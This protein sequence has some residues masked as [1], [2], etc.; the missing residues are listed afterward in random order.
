MYNMSDMI[1]KNNRDYKNFTTGNSYHVY[2][3][4]N[5]KQSIFVDDEDKRIFLFFL[6]EGVFPMYFMDQKGRRRKL[7]PPNQFGI[8]AYS[9][10]PNHYHLLI[11]QYSYTSICK[12]IQKV[13]TSYVKY[14]NNK[15]NRV[16]HLFQDKFKAVLI[17]DD[18]Q[19]QWTVEYIHNN[20]VEA[21]LV[22]RREDYEW[23]SCLHPFLQL[24]SQTW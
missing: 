24:Q 7:L 8:Q 6:S 14:F 20:C 18:R 4:G 16:G 5:N 3:R 2:N 13:C 11:K 9:I 19:F 17:K 12:L 15:Y 10:M 22:E 23:S 1:Y 21:K